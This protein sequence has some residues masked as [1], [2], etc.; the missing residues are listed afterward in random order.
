MKTK[1]LVAVTLLLAL[2]SCRKNVQEGTKVFFNVSFS[3]GENGKLEATNAN[4]TSFSAGKAEKDSIITFTAK[5]NDNY[6]VDKWTITGG[7]KING[8]GD[9]Q[10]TAEVKVTSD[11][12]VQVIFKKIIKQFN[13]SFS[14]GENGKLEA[15]NANGTS[16][17]A[18]KAEKDSIIT[19]T[20]KPNDNYDVDKWTITGGVTTEGGNQGDKVTKVKIT[21]NVDV[22]VTFKKISEQNTQF[23]VTFSNG[24]NGKL[25]ATTD[26]GN[27]FSAGKAEKDSIITFTAT[28]NNGY[29]VDKWTITGGETKEGGNAGNRVTKVKITSNVDVRVTFKKILKQFNVTFS[30]GENGKLEATNANGTSFSAGKAEKDSIITFTAKPNDNYD[31]DKWTITGGTKI[32]GGGDGQTTAEV[33]VTSDVNVQV[34]FKKILKQFNVTFSSCPKGT[35]KATLNGN[36]FDGGNAQEDSIITFTATP[37]ENYIVDIWAITGGEIKEGGNAGDTVTK[38]QVTSDVNV[39]VTFR[40][41]LYTRVIFSQLDR[42]LASI[43][44]DNEINYIEIFEL[45]ETDVMSDDKET[46]SPLAAILTKHPTKRVAIKFGCDLPAI[47]SL[48]YC[49]KGCKNLVEAPVIPTS[50]KN[51]MG[52][53]YDCTNLT[54]APKLPSGITAMITTF[55]NCAELTEAPEIPKGVVNLAACFA[56]CVKLTKMPE[57]PEGVKKMDRAFNDCVKLTEVTELPESL[58]SMLKCFSGC[59]ALVKA[60][61]IPANVKNIEGCFSSCKAL[62]EVPNIPE[63]VKDMKECFSACSLLTEVP[64]IPQGVKEMTRCFAGCTALKKVT[65]QCPYIEGKFNDTFNGCSSLENDGIKVP[66]AELAKY[67]AN[68]TK[69]GTTQEKFAGI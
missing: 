48:K 22:R 37:S 64:A 21:S 31:V 23:D 45:K 4:G 33:K 8:G 5:P 42:Y 49:F 46:P 20:A 39:K 54:K 26:D 65:L 3:N 44:K 12:N 29:D 47:T 13:V 7:T 18:G 56:G 19:F 50:V 57:I 10:T 11:V 68:A 60:P 14:N 28:P 53:F 55:Y 40:D 36:S 59:I 30:N 9:G 62:K 58:D 35:L 52:A 34:T 67:Q 41:P 51:V 6:D 32:N 43:A 38:V 1:L 66:N 69:M 24:E 63:S 17:S 16:F 2:L 15:T 61:T 27:S 25:I